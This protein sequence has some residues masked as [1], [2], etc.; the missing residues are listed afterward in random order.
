MRKVLFSVAFKV[1]VATPFAASANVIREC[2]SH[3]SGAHPWDA[4]GPH[5]ETE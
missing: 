4:G 5:M 1:A 2:W 3:C